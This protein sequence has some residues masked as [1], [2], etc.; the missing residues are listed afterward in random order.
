VID[1]DGLTATLRRVNALRHGAAGPSQLEQL[2]VLEDTVDQLFGAS[3]S[4]A[5]YGSLVPGGSNHYLVQPL[6]G[7][8]S[9][10]HVEGERYET[11]WGAPQGYAAMRWIPGAPPIDVHVLITPALTDF[12]PTLDAFEGSDYRRSLVPV[13]RAGRLVAVANLYECRHCPTPRVERE[14]AV[15]VKRR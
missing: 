14:P 7:E 15:E 12:W 3:R 6:G 9:R 4:L 13:M 1:L 2:R 11:G 5:V 8:W 10:G